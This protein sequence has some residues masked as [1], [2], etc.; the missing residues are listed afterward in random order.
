[1]ADDAAGSPMMMKSIICAGLAITAVLPF[2]AQHALADAQA[3]IVNVDQST[4]VSLSRQPDAIVIGNPSIA[5]A[6]V[7]GS[8]LF[9]H[10]RSF[11]T[12]N[13]MVLD[14]KGAEL[15]NYELT[16]QLG[17]RYNLTMFKG[18]FQYSYVCAPDC[19]A[20]MHVGD[21]KDWFKDWVFERDKDKISLATGQKPSEVNQ[22]EPSQ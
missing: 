1:M 21:Q 14:E 17:G 12:T 16:V 19:E 10:G 7:Q 6:S 22:P 13:L 15:A 4:I 2:T 9:V 18:G 8:K 11:G 3:L 5:D 20:Q